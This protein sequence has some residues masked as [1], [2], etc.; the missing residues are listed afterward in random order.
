MIFNE[1]IFDKV[2][3][4]KEEKEGVYKRTSPILKF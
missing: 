1:V 3:N 2:S 4:T